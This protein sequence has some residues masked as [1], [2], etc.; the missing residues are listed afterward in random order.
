[1]EGQ[2]HVHA[3]QITA[4]GDLMF[5]VHAIANQQND[6]LGLLITMVLVAA[7]SSVCDTAGEGH[8]GRDSNS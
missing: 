3:E 8:G 5:D 1:M 4:G 6:V 7:V 2:R